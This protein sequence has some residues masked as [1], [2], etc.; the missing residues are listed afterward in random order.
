[1][2]EEADTNSLT[3]KG[4]RQGSVFIGADCPDF[5]K[6]APDFDEDAFYIVL[7]YCCAVVNTDFQRKEPY[8]EIIKATRTC[9]RDKGLLWGRNPRRL[10]LPVENENEQ[11]NVE[12]SIHD[13]AFIPHELFATFSPRTDHVIPEQH[14]DVLK[15]WIAKRYIRN[16]FPSSFN[17]RA[18]HVIKRMGDVLKKG[19]FT[20]AV[21]GIYLKLDPMEELASDEPYEVELVAI[22]KEQDR[23]TQREVISKFL[24]QSADELNGCQGVTISDTRVESETGITLAEFRELIRL[25]DYDFISLRNAGEPDIP[26]PM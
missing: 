23:I 1:M 3:E 24:G 10:Q 9:T 4:W 15:Y 12:L 11:F 25:D 8:L 6:H 26:L 18:G 20:D 13:R 22:T 2:S 5:S 7:P 17:E 21:L 14:R 19:S 16:A